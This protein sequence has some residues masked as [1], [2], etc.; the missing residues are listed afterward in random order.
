MQEMIKADAQFVKMQ[1]SDEE[2]N[3]IK[4]YLSKMKTYLPRFALLTALMDMIF[5]GAV[6]EITAHHLKQGRKIC[7]YFVASARAVFNEAET[8]NEIANVSKAKVMGTKVEQILY[9]ASKGYKNK[10][11]AKTLKTPASYVSKVIS[12]NAKNIH[13]AEVKQ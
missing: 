4:T 3:E 7:D 11:I 10:D 1:T 2:T 12:D 6:P 8:T 5:T 13:K 9:L